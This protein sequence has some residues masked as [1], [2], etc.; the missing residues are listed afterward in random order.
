VRALDGVDLDLR[1]GEVHALVGPNGSGKSTALRV[2]AGVVAPATGSVRVGGLAVAGSAAAPRVRAGV[3][4]TLQHTAMLGRLPVA[5]QVEVGARARERA[6]YAG[7]RHLL[8]TASAAR[9]RRDRAAATAAALD[10]TGLTDRAGAEPDLLDTAEQRLLQIARAV[11][12]GASAVLV[13]EPAAGMSR[14]Q[15]DRLGAILRRLADSGRGVLLVEHDMNLVGRVAD[16]VTVL[17]EGRVL[18][19]GT[20]EAIRA[21]PDVAR[22]YL[23][24]PAD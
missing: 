16:R 22:A 18:A 2:A 8:G 4:R 1:G 15:R 24:V 11:A 20:P 6:S 5:R 9:E 19:T 12:T 21:D 14:Q 23:G 3:A 10:L 17:A 7:L 13:D